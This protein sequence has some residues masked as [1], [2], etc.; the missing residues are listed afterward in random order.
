MELP[1][2]VQ[3]AFGTLLGAFFVVSLVELQAV[4]GGRRAYADGAL[5]FGTPLFLV[6]L[7]VL[8]LQL[9]LTFRL[10][11]DPADVAERYGSRGLYRIHLA[12]GGLSLGVAL[13]H[14]AHSWSARRIGPEVLYDVLRSDLGAPR[15]LFAYLIGLTAACFFFGQGF[16]SVLRSWGLVFSDARPARW[17]GWA[18]AVGLWLLGLNALSHFAVGAPI[19]WG[20]A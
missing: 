10:R 2:K 1:P 4:T 20:A 6:A 5:A 9:G 11:R 18:G 7:I 17:V 13:L 3:A 15:W 8:A 14:V 12:M 16:A 19:L